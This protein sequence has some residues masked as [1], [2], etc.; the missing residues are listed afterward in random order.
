MVDFY[1]YNQIVETTISSAQSTQLPSTNTNFKIFRGAKT[2]VDFKLRDLNTQ[3]INLTDK[4]VILNVF[5]YNTNEF[6]FFKELEITDP[7]RGAARAVFDIIDTIDLTPSYFYYSLT[8]V[9]GD[10]ASPYFID[11]TA[12]ALSYFELIDGVMPRPMPTTIVLE[13]QYTPTTGTTQSSPTYW[14]A[15]P[16]KGDSNQYRDDGLHT[17]VVFCENF[18]GQFYVEVS[19]NEEPLQ[20]DWSQIWL[21]ELVPYKVYREFTGV[22]PFNFKANVKWVRFKYVDDQDQEGAI[23]RLMYRN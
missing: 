8:A 3:L 14:V 21:D 10:I 23:K 7:I 6:Q 11:Q 4:K 18:S 9:D 13:G 16:F 20:D 19:L 2:V 1:S 12:N 5:S 15:G 22:E 17:V